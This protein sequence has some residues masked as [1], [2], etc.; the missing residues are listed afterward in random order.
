M[1]LSL[2]D[3]D[4]VE[5]YVVHPLLENV[6]YGDR[7]ES[8]AP[9][10]NFESCDSENIGVDDRIGEEPLNGP[11]TPVAFTITHVVSTAT[12]ADNTTTPSTSKDC[13][14]IDEPDVGP[15]GDDFTDDGSDYSTADSGE[16]EN[17]GPVGEDDEEYESDVHEKV[18]ELRAERRERAPPDSE[19]GP[20]IEFDETEKGKI[21]VEGM[22]G[23]DEPY[24]YPSS[25]YDY[26]KIDEDEYWDEHDD[27]ESGRANVPRRVRT[28][29]RSTNGQKIIHDPKS[30]ESCMAVGGKGELKKPTVEV[31]T[32]AKKGREGPKTIAPA[33]EKTAPAEFHASSSGPIP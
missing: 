21:S 16:S 17:L 31:E 18:R 30:Q 7:E 11:N 5:V 29:R 24:Y 10:N 3:G 28:S 26:F 2:K 14:N 1:C 32:S 27:A 22:L 8:G 19:V 33:V 12:I 23:G 13:P 4:I 6:S 15:V 25:D 20:D 9:F